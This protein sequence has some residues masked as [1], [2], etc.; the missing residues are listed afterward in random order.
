MRN[1]IKNLK[2]ELKVA[3][4][5]AKM[6][7]YKFDKAD[8]KRQSL[9]A[10]MQDKATTQVHPE[11]EQATE[12]AEAHHQAPATEAAAAPPSIGGPA[13]PI[14]WQQEQPPPVND[15]RERVKMEELQSSHAELLSLKEALAAAETSREQLQATLQSELEET[16]DKLLHTAE[17]VQQRAVLRFDA[18]RKELTK[19]SQK[20]EAA[21][22]HECLQLRRELDRVTHERDLCVNLLSDELRVAESYRAADDKR[23]RT[24]KL[25]RIAA[26]GLGIAY[27]S[28]LYPLKREL[29]RLRE[30]TTMD[31][32]LLLTMPL[33]IRALDSRVLK[34]ERALAEAKA[35]LEPAR[36][37]LKAA[38]EARNEAVGAFAAQTAE[39]SH[40]VQRSEEL[41]EWSSHLIGELTRAGT[42]V[43]QLG[44]RL[45][46]SRKHENQ[47][48]KEVHVWASRAELSAGEAA[49]M[50]AR[51]GALERSFGS[52][53]TPG[54]VP[55][56]KLIGGPQ[57]G[58]SPRRAS[59][60][61]SP[62]RPSSSCAMMR[63]SASTPILGGGAESCD[64][65]R[66]QTPAS[67]QSPSRPMSRSSN[68]FAAL[69]TERRASQP[70]TSP[71][72]SPS[73]S[74][75]MSSCWKSAP[76]A[77]PS[78]PLERSSRPATSKGFPSGRLS[79]TPGRTS[80]QTM[81]EAR[82]QVQLLSPGP[83][84]RGSA[85]VEERV[86]TPNSHPF[87]AADVGVA[88][89]APGALEVFPYRYAAPPVPSV[90]HSATEKRNNAPQPQVRVDLRPWRQQPYR[91]P[92]EVF[93]P[94]E[95]VSLWP[96]AE[97]SPWG[98]A[99]YESQ[100]SQ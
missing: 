70:P 13:I 34:A 15:E 27:V 47:A 38:V 43:R 46:K 79:F 74:R 36:E 55:F 42:Q 89:E 29:R 30:K 97:V 98:R 86:L 16:K 100:G 92:S 26:K 32:R 81:L 24:I 41:D 23:E 61:S 76:N 57:K 35:E 18:E 10:M 1:E 75:P 53:V 64:S 71:A 58:F 62:S 90:S 52:L 6:M 25:Q 7:R 73:P 56:G 12:E 69:G 11:A 94:K 85:S 20:A 72:S 48:S 2:S 21:V 96:P 44:A 3:K 68:S 28:Q 33:K 59:A 8:K 54:G 9:A 65:P 66:A 87:A 60:F 40:A 77:T 19:A 95:S 63:P 5:D 37:A 99:S 31:Q 83:P 67:S 78:P 93:K 84:E 45:E 80:R 88:S 82:Q 91:R 17:D 14:G 22:K 51:M 50:E 4:E 49:K 39:L